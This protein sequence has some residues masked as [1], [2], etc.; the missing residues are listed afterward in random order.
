[1]ARQT[2]ELSLYIALTFL[3][4][5]GIAVLVLAAPQ[6]SENLFGP[7]NSSAPH[8]YVAVYAPAIAAIAVTSIFS[9]K[10][11]LKT[12]FSGYVRKTSA[13][14][15]VVGLFIFPLIFLAG[16][17]VWSLLGLTEGP[18]GLNR[19]LVDLP[20]L[21]LGW[22]IFQDPGGFGEE[23][24]W[25][26]FALPRLLQSFSPFVAS[27]ILGTIWIV[28]HLP[29]FLIEAMNHPLYTLIWFAGVGIGATVIMTWLYL[30]ANRNIAVAGVIP[31]LVLNGCLAVGI[32]GSTWQSAVAVWAF[33]A[34]LLLAF[35]KAAWP[36]QQVAQAA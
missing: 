17:L 23:L 28:W 33:V 22:R 8:F 2:K 4:T 12:L 25:R 5:W 14:W 36:A 6:V 31:H 34:V 7:L 13:A 29:Q 20:L 35:R 9:G 26:G 3:I 18:V 27:L 32:A 10:A 15:W 16:Q 1:M 19:W 11:G 30:R 24:G 21:F